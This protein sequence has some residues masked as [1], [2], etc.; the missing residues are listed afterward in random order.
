MGDVVQI[1]RSGPQVASDPVWGVG[2]PRRGS[3]V[4]RFG[5]G[6]TR[7]VGIGPD[8]AKLGRAA[9]PIRA[10]A[11]RRGSCRARPRRWCGPSP[12]RLRRRRRSRLRS[13]VCRQRRRLPASRRSGRGARRSRF[14]RGRAYAGRSVADQPRA[15]RSP[16]SRKPA[17][18]PPAAPRGRGRRQQVNREPLASSP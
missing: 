13:R 12:W 16:L 15:P 5:S 10:E 17:E 7:P 2:V 14:A 1:P 9:E 6:S 11:D 8:R 3:G 4:A 18:S